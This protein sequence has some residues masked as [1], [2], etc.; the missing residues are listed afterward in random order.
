MSVIPSITI[1]DQHIHPFGSFACFNCDISIFNK[2]SHLCQIKKQSDNTFIH[3]AQFLHTLQEN[4]ICFKILTNRDKYITE[5]ENIERLKTIFGDDFNLYTTFYQ[6]DNCVG[7]E[8]TIEGGMFN[9][10]NIDQPSIKTTVVYVVLQQKCISSMD[11]FDS[12]N[13]E[14]IAQDITPVLQLLHSAGYVHDDITVN[15][16]VYCE[17]VN[18]FKLIDYGEM[19]NASRYTFTTIDKVFSREMTELQKALSRIE[20]VKAYNSHQREIGL[21]QQ[22]KAASS[23]GSSTTKTNRTIRKRPP[24]NKKNRNIKKK[25]KYTTRKPKYYK[26]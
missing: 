3:V 13:T 4:N 21:A 5:Y 18:R 25:I 20:H 23:G 24:Y 9:I 6:Y 2:I 26:K 8:I 12:C 22:K 7:F 19:T 15:N 16:I 10:E 14:Q 1:C 11:M 17:C